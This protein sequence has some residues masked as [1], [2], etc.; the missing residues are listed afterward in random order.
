MTDSV[1]YDQ[2]VS[3]SVRCTESLAQRAPASTPIA[4]AKLKQCQLFEYDGIN[5]TELNDA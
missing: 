2:A 1:D 4:R 3:C 5:F